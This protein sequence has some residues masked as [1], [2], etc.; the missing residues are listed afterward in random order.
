[1][2]LLVSEASAWRCWHPFRLG[3]ARRPGRSRLVGR[4][5]VL[6]SD[7]A[8]L[9]VYGRGCDAVRLCPAIAQGA[10]SG[11]YS[12]MWPGALSAL[13]VLSNSTP[14]GVCPRVAP[15]V[16]QRAVPDRV[17]LYA[18]LLI[19]RLRFRTRLP[20]RAGMLAGYWALF[21]AFPGPEG[22]WSEDRQHRSGDRLERARLQ[23]LR[24]LHHHQLHRQRRH[25]PVRVLGRH[26]AAHPGRTHDKLKILAAC[27]A[28]RFAWVLRSIPSTP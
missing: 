17:R 26:A 21:A 3:L 7:P 12:G 10:N 9:H 4:L 6:G 15:A 23:L 8:G 14:T 18:L 20:H 22:P 19:I 28:P 2:L 25:H 11:S 24:L 16:H 5:Y 13:I 1:M 27:A